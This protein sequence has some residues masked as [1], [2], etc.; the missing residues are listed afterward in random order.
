[1]KTSACIII[2]HTEINGKR[3]GLYSSCY[4]RVLRHKTVVTKMEQP[5][6]KVLA[7]LTKESASF[8]MQSSVIEVK[9]RKNIVRW[10]REHIA[11]EMDKEKKRW[12]VEKTGLLAYSSRY[13]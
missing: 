4:S 1:M 12:L 13:W 5:V 11:D 2:S 3:G 8:R 6:E 7:E 9:V 10:N